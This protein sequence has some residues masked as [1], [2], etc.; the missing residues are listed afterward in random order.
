[1]AMLFVIAF[2]ARPSITWAL[3]RHGQEGQEENRRAQGAGRAEGR[4]TRKDNANER[5]TAAKQSKKEAKNSKKKGRDHDDDDDDMD[6][7]SVL[8]QYKREVN[9]HHTSRTLV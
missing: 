6:I 3:G 5:Q 2:D 9:P 8:E 4:G 7:D 1:V